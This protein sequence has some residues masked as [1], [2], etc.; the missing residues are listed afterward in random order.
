MNRLTS[1]GLGLWLPLL[2]LLL[3]GSMV[4]ALTIGSVPV[5]PSS[6][7]AVLLD[8]IP[9][10]PLEL[11]P[12]ATHDAIIWDVRLPR[13]LLAAIVG[14]GLSLVGAALQA[15]V[16]NPLADPYILGISSG[17]SVGAALVIVFGFL[18]V[19]GGMALSAASCVGAFLTLVGVFLLARQGN[20]IPVVRL[21]LAGIATSAIL[22]ALTSFLLFISPRE[23]GVSEVYFWIMGSLSGTRW[24]TLPL[25]ATV[26]I[27][28]TLVILT[29]AR[30]M[31]TMLMGDETAATLGLNV[32]RFRKFLL[33]FSTVVTGVIVAVS[34]S[35][36]FVGLVVPHIARILLGAD[37]RRLLPVVALLG[38][39]FL[40]GADVVARI[41][42]AP[43]E[44]PIG[45]ITALTGGPFFIWLMRRRHYR[46]GDT[47]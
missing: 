15:L 19:L 38:A 10:L 27:V 6:V 18:S 23:S 3:A 45:I 28:G 36:G 34:G 1:A 5:P 7:L 26:V 24:W 30:D 31:N 20:R 22:S 17:A 11:T 47:E 29:R 42:L 43:Q 21:L 37:H 2:G 13:V 32:P 40:V 4:L 39:I 25:P 41:I 44:L 46:F 35:I 14:A 8:R 12:S 9:L 33:V 16:R